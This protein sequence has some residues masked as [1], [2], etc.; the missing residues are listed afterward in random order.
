[1]KSSNV[2]TQPALLDFVQTAR[3]AFFVR[4]SRLARSAVQSLPAPRPLVV[5]TGGLRSLEALNDVIDSQH[6]DLLGIGRG[7][8]LTPDLPNRLSEHLTFKNLIAASP[9]L[10]D[11]ELSAIFPLQPTFAPTTVNP[12][13]SDP[14]SYILHCLT[15]LFTFLGILP[16]PHLIGAGMGMAWY[17]VQMSRLTRQKGIDYKLGAWAAVAEMWGMSMG[18]ED[19]WVMGLGIGLTIGILLVILMEWLVWGPRKAAELAAKVALAAN[20]TLA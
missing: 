12:T 7:S 4:F 18:L 17:T 1:M 11:K 13:T 20:A 15:R 14:V 19:G 5:L 10:V 9:A 3:Q 16:L 8:V 2:E 6:A